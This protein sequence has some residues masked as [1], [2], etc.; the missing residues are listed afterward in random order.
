MDADPLRLTMAHYFAAGSAA[1]MQIEADCSHATAQPVCH[2]FDERDPIDP[3]NVSMEE[4]YR[5]VVPLYASI[6]VDFLPDRLEAWE[7]VKP[8]SEWLHQR[9]P[10]ILE[11]AGSVGLLYRG[12]TW[13]PRDG[14]P[15]G[16]S[17]I[18]VLNNLT[19]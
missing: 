4:A 16:A 11:T 10:A 3:V 14:Q 13:E 7:T 18:Q 1:I 8:S 17:D 5:H 2:H 19:V 6:G 9:V 12:W 15:I